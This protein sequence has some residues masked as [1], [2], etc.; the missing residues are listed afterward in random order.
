M[1]YKC[2]MI[3]TFKL[4]IDDRSQCAPFAP[5]SPSPKSLLNILKTILYKVDKSRSEFSFQINISQVQIFS[6][7]K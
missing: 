6:H 3:L 2:L 7:F 5:S 4:S 1:I